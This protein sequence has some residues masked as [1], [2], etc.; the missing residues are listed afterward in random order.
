M[1]LEHRDAKKRCARTRKKLLRAN[2]TV[3]FFCLLSLTVLCFFISFSSGP[4]KVARTLLVT[5]AVSLRPANAYAQYFCRLPL[6][7][8]AAEPARHKLLEIA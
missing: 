3:R 5:G 1:F 6:T 2:R 7:E 4:C 8:P